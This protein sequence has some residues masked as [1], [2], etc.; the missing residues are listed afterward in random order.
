M[1]KRVLLIAFICGLMFT[2]CDL[3]KDVVKKPEVTLKSVDFSE[4]DFDGLTLLSTVGVKNNYSI[5]VPL[6]KID[7]E[8]FVIESPFV[9]GTIESEGSLKSNGLTEVEFPVNFTY[10]DLINTIINLTDE[11]AKYKIK[12]TAHI[13]VPELGDLSWPF[14]HEGKIPIM[15]APDITVATAPSA[16]FTYGLIPGVPTGGKIDFDLKVKNNSNVAVT[17]NDLSYDFKISGYLLSQGGVPNKPRINPGATETITV[18]FP[19]TAADILNVGTGVLASSNFTYIL[20]GNYKF[21]I[22]E[23]PLLNEVGDTFTLP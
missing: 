11:N 18:E 7:W 19:L 4:V 23:F 17:V 5:E 14:E 15:R 10:V 20:T 6:P 12:M 3:L 2:T 21:G 22:P 9:N 13:P 8:L 1:K 16:S